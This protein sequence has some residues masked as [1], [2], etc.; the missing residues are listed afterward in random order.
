M[1]T[2][3]QHLQSFW[4]FE[5]SKLRIKINGLLYYLRKIPLIGKKI[6]ETIYKNYE[7]K[8]ILFVLGVIANL[9]TKVLMKGLWLGIP[10]AMASF[11]PLPVS[12]SMFEEGIIYWLFLVPLGMNFYEGFYQMLEPKE[13]DY[14]AHYQISPKKFFRSQMFV[15]TLY[16]GLA[17]LPIFIV[18]GISQKS[19]LLPINL[20][21]CY[22]TSGFVFFSLGRKLIDLKLPMRIAFASFYLLF[23]L[24]LIYGSAYFDV[25]EVVLKGVKSF[26]GLLILSGLLYI[27]QKKL[28]N[29]QKEGEY[30]NKVMAKSFDLKTKSQLA[31][32]STNTY[33]GDGIKMQKALTLGG[34]S[35]S[36]LKGSHYLNALLFSRYGV[37][38]K[39]QLLRR[40]LIILSVGIGGV[41]L[42]SFIGK[43]QLTEKLMIGLLPTLFFVMYLAN[44]GK[45]IVQLAFIN[46]DSS[47]LFYPFYREAKTIL[48][49]FFFRFWKTLLYNSGIALAIFLPIACFGL[50]NPGILSLK[51]FLILTF[52]LISL[53]CLFSFHELFIYYLLQ[54]FT[55]DLEVINPIY[56]GVSGA[57]YWV[58][59]LNLQSNASGLNYVIIISVASL[60]Y[61]LIG[62]IIISLVAP[63]TF[64]FKG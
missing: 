3:S 28:F 62:L 49:G 32:S 63:K 31:A 59:Y 5:N 56:K 9:L 33:L 45:K 52:L 30:F 7:L 13:L 57:L 48:A 34:K 37:T 53:A 54:P 27:S 41:V 46:C 43:E 36:N 64:R 8:D 12:G 55:S 2:I 26:R 50:V 11:N 18:L 23:L 51:F 29:Y 4:Y 20:I 47:M 38:L 15:S 19:G 14:V 35:Y 40:V 17:Y 60:L 25:N 44:F 24:S 16:N 10:L 1:K 61:V 21:L 6:P 42:L 58:A 22:L 39:K